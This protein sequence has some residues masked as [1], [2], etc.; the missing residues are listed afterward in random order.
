MPL[1]ERLSALPPGSVRHVRAVINGTTN[2]ILD[3]VSGGTS[4]A[5]ALRLAQAYGYAEADPSNDLEGI[6]AAEKLC[7]VARA[8]GNELSPEDVDRQALTAEAIA[9]AQ[10][11]C[12]DPERCPSRYG[13]PLRHVASLTVGPA[14]VEAEVR[15]LQVGPEDPLAK[16]RD[17]GNAAVI[18]LADGRC[19]VI[20]GK[21]AGRWPTAEAVLADV[22]EMARRHDR[23]AVESPCQAEAAGARRALALSAG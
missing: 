11:P 15:L 23:E 6:D 1:L 14:G 12:R 8:I 4:F 19:D 20:Q 21:G 3:R 5:A 9:A 17:A 10:A 2:F 18:E 16:A 7:L 13:G 22:L